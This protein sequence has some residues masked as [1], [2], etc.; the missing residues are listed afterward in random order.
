MDPGKAAPV[1]FIEDSRLFATVDQEGKTVDHGQSEILVVLDTDYGA[2]AEELVSLAGSL[3]QQLLQTEVNDVQTVRSGELP[4]GAK[5]AGAVEWG[6]LLIT[7][8]KSKHVIEGVVGTL[9]AWVQRN[10]GTQAHLKVGPCDID[11]KGMQ[12]DQEAIQRML[13]TCLEERSRDETPATASGPA[14]E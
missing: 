8:A 1:A 12:L 7:L 5:A 14:E 9:T 4:D 13:E 6:A 11:L 10:Q 2:G 3:R